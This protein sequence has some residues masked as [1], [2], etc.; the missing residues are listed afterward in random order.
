MTVVELRGL[1]AQR[2]HFASEHHL[3]PKDY[4]EVK[5]ALAG[6]GLKRDPNMR[7]E[8]LLFEGVRVIRTWEP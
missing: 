2:R 8:H 3:S 5:A 4:D 7:K 6:T 1:I